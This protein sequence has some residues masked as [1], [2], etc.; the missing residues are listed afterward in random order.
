MNMKSL[1]IAILAPLLAAGACQ[2]ALAADKDSPFISVENGSFTREGAPYCF[3]GTN[4]WYGAY[5]G[6]DSSDGDRQR[7]EKE[8][9]LLQASGITNLRILGGSE[10]SPLMNS[11]QTTFR[12]RSDQYN[13]QLLS[14][15]DF[16]L[17]EMGERGMHAV[18]YLNNF[19]TWGGYGRGAHEDYRWLEG[20]RSYTGDPPQE[21]Q[22]LNSIFGSDTDTLKTIQNHAKNLA[23]I[24]CGP[25]VG[26]AGSAH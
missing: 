19:W 7:L 9:D 10:K 20:D 2:S 6:S 26:Q 12:D 8:L 23:K 14:G 22:G 17:S 18:I 16:L 24:G 13:E 21:A 4:L 5:L 15:L 3:A 11:L 25:I 1:A